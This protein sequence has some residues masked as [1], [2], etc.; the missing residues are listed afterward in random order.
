MRHGERGIVRLIRALLTCW[1]LA[2]VLPVPLAGAW[3]DQA[4]MP[5]DTVSWQ[6]PDTVAQSPRP[7]ERRREAKA[8][9][10]RLRAASPRS[11]ASSVAPALRAVPAPERDRRHLY[12]EQLSLLC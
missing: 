2:S 9:S 3:A 10:P 5:R 12:L 11:E 6:A 1:L 7:P 8:P 4:W